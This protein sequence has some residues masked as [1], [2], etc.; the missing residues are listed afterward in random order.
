M[1]LKEYIQD[2]EVSQIDG[3]FVCFYFQNNL[4]LVSNPETDLRPKGKAEGDYYSHDHLIPLTLSQ[5]SVISGGVRYPEGVISDED[6][7]DHRFFNALREVQE[8]T[9]L[10]LDIDRLRAINNKPTR[11]I[12]SRNGHG[13]FDISGYGFTYELT[14]N[15]FE[16]LCNHILSTDRNL[17]IGT[18]DQIWN[19]IEDIDLR[20]FAVSA[21]ISLLLYVE[22]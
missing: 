21:L 16:Q 12:Q 4:I 8:E 3:I 1:S 5:L 6:K 9:S 20:P 22:S 10:E 14:E 13:L 19:T 11:T 17:L 18:F 2:K 15:E 7:D